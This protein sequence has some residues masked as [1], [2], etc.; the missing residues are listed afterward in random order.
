VLVNLIANATQA[1]ASTG[2]GTRI[3]VAARVEDGALVLSVT[4]D[5][6]GFA[7]EVRERLFQP[8]VTTRRSGAGLGLALCHRIVEK[9]GGTIEAEDPPGGGARIVI[10]I[11]DATER[12]E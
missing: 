8:L 3:V 11:P 2:R 5:G 10:R 12:K 7:K 4:D 6:P 1:I 9:H